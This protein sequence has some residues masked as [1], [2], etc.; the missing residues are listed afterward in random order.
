M[1]FGMDRVA[2]EWHHE[3]IGLADRLAAG[4]VL[5]LAFI[6]GGV[7]VALGLR[8]EPASTNLPHLVPTEPH[9]LSG[10]ARSSVRAR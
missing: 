8:Y 10:A 7:K 2:V 6:L 9:P 4:A 3:P 5:E 1:H